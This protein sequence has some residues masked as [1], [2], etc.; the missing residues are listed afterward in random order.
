MW[1][2]GSLI[3][4]VAVVMT[5]GCAGNDPAVPADGASRT[6]GVAD[7]SKAAP[8]ASAIP[9]PATSGEASCTREAQPMP[10]PGSSASSDVNDRARR[11]LAGQRRPSPTRGVVPEAAVS[12]A[13]TC[14]DLLRR[15]FAL[16]EAGSRTA[17]DERAIKRALGSAG[18]VHVVVRSGPVF[19]ASTGAACIHGDLTRT[20][21]GFIIGPPAADGLCRG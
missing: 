5:A 20:E 7:G 1:R 15:E 21:P 2:Y 9:A 3:V 17:P 18:L 12:G 8:V 13:E 16:I 14:I 19:A 4:G 11:A 10:A 6:V